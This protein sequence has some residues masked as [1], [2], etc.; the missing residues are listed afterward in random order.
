MYSRRYAQQRKREERRRLGLCVY[1]GRPAILKGDGQYA[2]RCEDCTKSHLRQKQDAKI[3]KPI[4]DRVKAIRKTIK[5]TKLTEKDI[6][7]ILD[8]CREKAG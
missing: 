5:H 4:E 2:R 8:K 6:R 1:C 7:L 3:K